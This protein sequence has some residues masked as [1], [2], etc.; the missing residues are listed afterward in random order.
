MTYLL[1]DEAVCRTAPATPG[2]LIIDVQLIPSSNLSRWKI[3]INNLRSKVN[4]KEKVF[5]DPRAVLL[6][7]SHS[8]PVYGDRLDM[9]IIHSGP[10]FKRVA[11][12]STQEC[13]SATVQV[14]A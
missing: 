10:K 14:I 11:R 1:H 12:Q 6:G 4:V 7:A 8:P 9:A 5:C 13:T 2:L 3:L